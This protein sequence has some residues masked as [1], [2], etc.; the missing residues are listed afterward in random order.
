MPSLHLTSNVLLILILTFIWP[1]TPHTALAAPKGARTRRSPYPFHGLT[2]GNDGVA[3]DLPQGC[4]L[5]QIQLVARHGTRRPGKN[6]IREIKAFSKFLKAHGD[7]IAEEY[8]WMVDWTNP[9][10]KSE[11]NLLVRAGE[12]DL[13]WFGRRFAKRY[14]DLYRNT[15][16]SPKTFTFRSSMA[17]RSGQSGSAFASGFF[18][19]TSGGQCRSQ[20][21]HQWTVPSNQDKVLTP[22]HSCPLWRH[23]SS[24]NTHL[25]HEQSLFR[26]TYITPI[27]SRLS[28]SLSSSPS[29]P[30]P[31][32]PQHIHTIRHLCAFAV[33]LAHSPKGHS[34][35]ERDTRWCGVL[36][37]EEMEVLEYWEDMRKW[38]VLGGG[39]G[40]NGR[41]GCGVLGDV[42]GSLPGGKKGKDGV[43]EEGK[44]KRGMGKRKGVFRF[45]HS[46]TN[47]F[48]L[49]A[50]NLYNDTTPLTTSNFPSLSTRQFRM[51]TLSPFASNIVFEVASCPS[52]LK[53][54]ALVNE[55]DTPILPGCS[56]PWCD[57]EDLKRGVEG[58]V[59][60]GRCVW[61]RV[62]GVQEGEEEFGDLS[63]WEDVEGDDDWGQDGEDVDWGDDEEE[64]DGGVLV[65]G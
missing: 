30:F 27:V 64:W 33:S 28:S 37:R 61:G 58:V 1:N 46:E 65:Q 41:V 49:S 14:G 25:A 13:Y 8:R 57:V 42:V 59:G 26:S 35:E 23:R 50:L 16:Y 56:D 10:K 38:F 18:Y 53:L 4:E 29:S 62:C 48:L 31:L 22:K 36:E 5:V 34:A 45:G 15:T 2:V 47:V 44:G 3:L 55:A 52:S 19:E 17:S 11:A 6:T 60:E 40:F 54:R 32:I 7:N 20:A 63:A 39:D 9:Y 21:V 51:S 12:D 43:L 24:H